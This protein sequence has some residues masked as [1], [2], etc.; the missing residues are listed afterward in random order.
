LL[1]EA[2]IQGRPGGA[3]LDFRFR[4]DIASGH[5]GAARPEFQMAIYP[6]ADCLRAFVGYFAAGIRE[7]STV[8]HYHME[9]LPELDGHVT[10]T[11]DLVQHPNRRGQIVQ[12]TRLLLWGP[13]RQAREAASDA[14]H[15]VTAALVP[16]GVF[17]LT[18]IPAEELAGRAVDLEDIWGRAARVLAARLEGAFDT[19]TQAALLEEAVRERVHA[20]RS[21]PHARAVVDFVARADGDMRVANLAKQIGYSERHLRRVLGRWI[22]LGPKSAGRVTRL[23]HALR[24]AVQEATPN[25]AVAAAATGYHDQA[26]LSADCREMTGHSPGR[27]VAGVTAPALLGEWGVIVRRRDAPAP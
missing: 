2:T 15:I 12:R 8:T 5:G 10:Y 26:H 3:E 23:R 4:T 11:K 20:A 24:V 22:G 9:R 19:Q 14:V 17:A 1:S 27:L 7:P 21:D 16:G 25:W 18:G 6:A 13:S